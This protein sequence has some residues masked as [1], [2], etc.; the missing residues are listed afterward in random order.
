MH[1]AAP[2]AALGA[3]PFDPGLDIDLCEK[4]FEQY[5]S[6]RNMQYDR[7]QFGFWNGRR[8]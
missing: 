8:W 2:W 4:G 5:Q 7:G 1:F 3:N 6:L